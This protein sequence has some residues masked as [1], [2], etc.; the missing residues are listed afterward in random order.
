MKISRSTNSSWKGGKAEEIFRKEEPEWQRETTF[1]VFKES[2]HFLFR[3][4][5]QMT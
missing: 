3:L 5:K 1:R 4:R 2:S